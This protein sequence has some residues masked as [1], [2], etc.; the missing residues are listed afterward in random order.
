MRKHTFRTVLTSLALA[1]FLAIGWS[2]AES[3]LVIGAAAEISHLDPR[4]ATD[5]HSFQRIHVISEPL[6]TFGND[7]GL[8][9]RLATD[10]GFSDDGLTLTFKLRE[11]VKF[12]DGTDFTSEDVKYTFEWV[13]DPENAAQNRPLYA[14]IES[15]DTPDAHTVV[16]KLSSVNSFLLNNIARMA[17]V[18]VSAG[19]NE[20]FTF[21][22]VGTG[23]YKFESL[24]RDDRLVLTAFDDYWGGRGEIDV[25]EFRPIPEDGTRLLAFEAG[26]IDITQSQP[27]PSEMERLE[28]DPRFIVERTPGTGYT[29]IG[30]NNDSAPLDNKLVRQAISHLVHRD[31]I[32]SRVLNGIGQPGVSMIS[33][34]LVWFNP[35]VPRFDYDP[36]RARELLAEAGFGD[37]G[38]SLRVH[39]NDAPVRM[40]IAEILQA[41]MAGIGIDLE[42]NI[43]EFGAFI[44]RIQTTN[45]YDMYILGFAG[46][47]DPDRSMQRQFLTTGSNNFSNYS[48]ARVDE[49][50]VVG[51]TVA[52]DSQESID[53]YNEAQM[54]VVEE[55]PYVYVNYTEEIALYHPW[56]EGWSIH[57]ENSNA[58]QDLHLV[59]LNR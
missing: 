5:S 55:A 30:L 42:I 2:S 39:T 32:V 38:L 20:D 17:I 31:A 13:I 12:H 57:T 1:A 54:I 3:R 24:R 27:V 53:I 56:V 50:L 9:P 52:P 49:L 29:Y 41:E 4:V 6:V 45:D 48:N 10:W 36:E 19:D 21:N 8:N 43:E 22:P 40:Q 28:A 46:Q 47:L 7:L 18:P 14:D 26:E 16:M 25:V 11:G 51:R 37:G 33:P 15:I 34:N 58:Y 35:D 59:K 23:P 44:D